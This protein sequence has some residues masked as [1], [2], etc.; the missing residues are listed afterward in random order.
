MSSS[1]LTL[2]TIPSPN[3]KAITRMLEDELVLL[4]PAE[5]SKVIVLNQ[6]GAAIWEL[7]DGQRDIQQIAAAITEQFDTNL[8]TAEAD[9]L[10]FTAKLVERGIVSINAET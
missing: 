7:L 5:K 1:K 6:V 3:P 4:V 2:E 10:R 9:T 8:P